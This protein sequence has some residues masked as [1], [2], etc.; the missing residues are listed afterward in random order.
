MFRKNLFESNFLLRYDKITLTT[1]FPFSLWLS[2]KHWFFQRWFAARWLSQNFHW[3]L[4]KRK[5]IATQYKS[6]K[7][8]FGLILN[9]TSL[10]SSWTIRAYKW[11]RYRSRHEFNFG[12]WTWNFNL[13]FGEA[14]YPTIFENKSR[15]KWFFKT[16]HSDFRNINYVTFHSEFAS[17]F[18]R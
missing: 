4:A 10:P 13:V 17:K 9:K 18:I 8:Q 6:V 16:R 3:N 5:I 15:K 2:L 7:K 11:I 1:L 14:D 12:L